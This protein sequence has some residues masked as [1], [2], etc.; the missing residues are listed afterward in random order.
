MVKFLPLLNVQSDAQFVERQE[1]NMRPSR[2]MGDINPKK[3]RVL[4]PNLILVLEL[5]VKAGAMSAI[6][7]MTLLVFHLPVKAT[8]MQQKALVQMKVI[9]KILEP[10]VPLQSL[11]FKIFKMLFQKQQMRL[12]VAIRKMQ[13]QNWFPVQKKEGLKAPEKA[14]EKVCLKVLHQHRRH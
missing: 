9:Q 7:L 10:Q 14:A 13:L 1:L 3:M 12:V 6:L 4:M 5:E 11:R 8:M 2:G